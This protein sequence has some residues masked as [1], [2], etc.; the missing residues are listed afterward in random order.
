LRLFAFANA[1]VAIAATALRGHEP[2]LL[3]TITGLVIG[4]PIGIV[5]ASA[6]AVF[7]GVAVK[8]SAYSWWQLIGAGCLAGIGFA[9]SLFIASE[10]FSDNTDLRRPK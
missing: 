9:M 4:K 1:G 2:L 10:A 3:A 8:P 5:V 6:L 7:L